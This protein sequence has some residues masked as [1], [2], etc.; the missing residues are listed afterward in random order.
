MRIDRA[1]ETGGGARVRPLVSRILRWTKRQWL[2]MPALARADAFIAS[3]PKSGRTW[4]R[5]IL[6]DYLSDRFDLGLRVDLQTMFGVLPNDDL[7]AERG[8]PAFGFG[9]RPGMPLVGGQPRALP[10][11]VVQE[12]ARRLPPARPA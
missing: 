2:L 6:A 9:D 4:L 8:L 3:Y 1:P 12:Q 5:F 10:A 11:P 7:S